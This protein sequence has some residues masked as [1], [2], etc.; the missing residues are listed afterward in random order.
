MVMSGNDE[1]VVF[2]CEYPGDESL[3]AGGTIARLRSRN[4]RVLLLFAAQPGGTGSELE[5]ACAE[6]DVS[7]W[8][9]LPSASVENPGQRGPVAGPV[10]DVLAEVL[11]DVRPTALV[12]ATATQPVQAAATAA[13]RRLGIPVFLSRRLADDVGKRLTAID[14]SDEVDQKARAIAAYASRWSVQDGAVLLPDGTLQAITGT[15]AYLRLEPTATEEMEELPP[16]AAGK[17]ATAV[18][19]FLV[20]VLFGVLG[21]VAH[22]A[23][24]SIGSVAIPVGLVLAL[25]GTTALLVG[26]R[27]VLHDRTAVLLAALGLLGTIFVLS[28]RSTG[29]SVLVP[30]GLVGT[31]WTVVPALV[32]ALALAWPKLPAKRPPAA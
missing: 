9:M 5:A 12:I 14:V 20:G 29:G 27:M 4:A 11:V 28:L 6:L 1:R 30:A 24:V 31:L 2:I 26:L 10:A 22:Q 16:T 21:T 8:R 23:T 25:S 19:G 17:L 15:E 18:F 3:V 13:A 7:D 32:A